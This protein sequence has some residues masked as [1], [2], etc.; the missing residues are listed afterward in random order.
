MIN[1]KRKVISIMGA[2]AAL[3]MALAVLF[4]IPRPLAV[5]A[6]NLP[7][8]S[9]EEFALKCFKPKNGDDLFQNYLIIPNYGATYDSQTDCNIIADFGFMK[10]AEN[11][12]IFDNVGNAPL[13]GASHTVTFL[14]KN[15][16]YILIKDF[17]DGNIDTQTFIE[18]FGRTDVDT[19][20]PAN[21][22]F[23]SQ[24]L[25]FDNYINHYGSLSSGTFAG[26]ELVAA[27]NGDTVGGKYLIS[28]NNENGVNE[29]CTLNSAN[30]ALTFG[31]LL[32]AGWDVFTDSYGIN[33]YS[34][35]EPSNVSEI[36]AVT[37]LIIDLCIYIP[38]S[39][40]YDFAT[41]DPDTGDVIS[42]TSGTVDYTSV[43]ISNVID[44]TYFLQPGNNIPTSE[45]PVPDDPGTSEP[46][47]SENPGTSDSGKTDGKSDVGE[48]IKDKADG[49]SDWLGENTGLK[50]SGG[51]II[52]LGI[53]I[54]LIT[55]FRRRR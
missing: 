24:T 36:K 21:T 32:S 10:I 37:G 45:E 19:T 15:K 40:E 17:K 23:S 6:D 44:G 2:V 29:I 27:K 16:E 8:L 46:G 18:D 4:T 13:S 28:T 38:E 12:Q 47:T 42:T 22:Y 52:V 26:W 5:K 9:N 14:L 39:A 50:I 48:W 41:V 35:G 43:T 1:V 54:I 3:F 20:I 55:V 34:L 25:L 7:V 30:P 53:G 31:W 33:S 51:F 49:L 11:L